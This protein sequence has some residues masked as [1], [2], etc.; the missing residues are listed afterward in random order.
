MYTNKFMFRMKKGILIDPHLVQHGPIQARPNRPRTLMPMTKETPAYHSTLPYS[1][2]LKSPLRKK[3]KKEVVND[4]AKA[5]VEACHA[6]AIREDTYVRLCHVL[7]NYS[8]FENQSVNEKRKDEILTAELSRY[9]ELTCLAITAIV[10]CNTITTSLCFIYEGNNYLEKI[11]ADGNDL[12][13]GYPYLLQYCIRYGIPTDPSSNPLFLTYTLQES[14]TASVLPQKEPRGY[15]MAYRILWE[16]L[17]KRQETEKDEMIKNCIDPDAKLPLITIQPAHLRALKATLHPTKQVVAVCI[18]L[19]IL[20]NDQ[21]REVPTVWKKANV[22]LDEP[23]LLLKKMH[24]F[25]TAIALTNTKVSALSPILASGLL[26]PRKLLKSSP[27]AAQLCLWILG[28][29]ASLHPTLEKQHGSKSLTEAAAVQPTEATDVQSTEAAAVH[30]LSRVEFQGQLDTQPITSL[31]SHPIPTENGYTPETYY[32]GTLQVQ[33]SAYLVHGNLYPLDKNATC[34]VIFNSITGHRITIPLRKVE[35]EEKIQ[36]FFQKAYH[37]LEKDDLETIKLHETFSLLFSQLRSI[38]KSVRKRKITI[39]KSIFQ[40]KIR[41]SS[42]SLNDRVLSD[43]HIDLG[44]EEMDVLRLGQLTPF[45]RLL[46]CA[47]HLLS[48]LF[49]GQGDDDRVELDRK[50]WSSKRS[51]LSGHTIRLEMTQRQDGLVIT[52]Y[53]ESLKVAPPPLF[54]TLIEILTFAFCDPFRINPLL[55]L[56]SRITLVQD[57]RFTNTNAVS[58]HF[59]RCLYT[60][61][62]KMSDKKILF[63]VFLIA[64]KTLRISITSIIVFPKKNVKTESELIEEKGSLILTFDELSVMLQVTK[65]ELS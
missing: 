5:E 2:P 65:T 19:S 38:S 27:T 50:V 22:I 41:I 44:F 17:K 45:S 32:L 54:V 7:Y 30:P 62:T 39:S 14:T 43:T 13:D 9:A 35:K 51:L 36:P 15:H 37:A 24:S 47:E 4:Q 64:E 63:K 23:I 60:A 10:Q 49:V 8:S 56:C 6:I 18:A 46:E 57:T 16:E 1:N 34:L 59:N 61:K 52:F 55:E 53:G 11:I 12:V 26:H 58:V 25:S 42:D 48:R 40:D 28:V 3:A 33:N 20:F 29:M 21:R 31:L